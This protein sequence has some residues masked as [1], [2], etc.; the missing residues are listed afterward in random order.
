MLWWPIFLVY[1]SFS[2]FIINITHTQKK[3]KIVTMSRQV[4][5]CQSHTHTNITQCF[6]LHFFPLWNVKSTLELFRFNNSTGQQLK[7]SSLSSLVTM[8]WWSWLL[9]SFFF[10]F[11]FYKYFNEPSQPSMVAKATNYSIIV[12]GGGIS[13]DSNRNYYFFFLNLITCTLSTSNSLVAI[14]DWKMRKNDKVQWMICDV[15]KFQ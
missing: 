4:W 11:E 7:K 10:F 2:C 6:F 14:S 13:V 15:N 9:K 8:W 5:Q 12:I 1:F 3:Q